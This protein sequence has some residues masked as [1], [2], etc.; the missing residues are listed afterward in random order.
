MLISTELV[1][2][3]F[4]LRNLMGFFL[5][6]QCDLIKQLYDINLRRLPSQHGDV[7]VMVIKVV[8]TSF[9]FITNNKNLEL[10]HCF[11]TEGD[12]SMH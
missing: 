11:F 7:S 4:I 12:N 8:I 3:T 2:L 10:Y 6:I 5:T 9:C 1:H